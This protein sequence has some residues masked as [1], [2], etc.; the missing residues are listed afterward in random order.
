[1]IWESFICLAAI[2]NASIYF[3]VHL[4]NYLSSLNTS[5][6]LVRKF[7]VYIREDS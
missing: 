5:L 4:E 3:D 2:V 6:Y 1:M 7:G